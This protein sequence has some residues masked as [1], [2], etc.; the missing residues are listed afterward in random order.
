MAESTLSMTYTDIAGAVGV[1]FSY[2]ATVASFTATEAEQVAVAIR[3]GLR[4]FYY[5]PILEDEKSAHTWS[6]LHP[7]ATLTSNAP[8]S[9]GTVTVVSGVVTLASGTFPSWAAQG[10][11]LVSGTLYD[12]STR[13]SNSQ[14]TL[15]DTTLNVDAGTSYSLYQSEITLPDNF[16]GFDDAP[17]FITPS[18]YDAN[19]TILDEQQ[20]R[21]LRGSFGATFARPAYIADRCINATATSGQRF[22]ALFYPAFD[23][24][25]VM[26]YTYQILP[27]M[28]STT[29]YPLGG[30]IHAETILASCLHIAA[31]M[32]KDQEGIERKRADFM[33]R[34]ASSV[35][36]DR[37]L[38]AASRIM[39]DR[40]LNEYNWR[41]P[42]RIARGVSATYA[43][44]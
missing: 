34:L 12:V 21:N 27:D 30:S 14:V 3:R 11:V 9:T 4:Q 38:K 44:F 8:Y 39:T 2:G 37:S 33:H 5:P 16:G 29:Q 7:F 10:Q 31:Q 28:I 42:R 17:T 36:H 13:D 22:E 25:Y 23:A 6:F 32:L 35:S 20:I 26:G 43:G 24:S 40:E 15:H 41:H 19:L 18:L 1:L